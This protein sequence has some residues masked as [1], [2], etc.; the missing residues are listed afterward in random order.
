MTTIKVTAE[1]VFETEEEFNKF[2]D[3]WNCCDDEEC[4]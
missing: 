3:D 2:M 1:L 4:V